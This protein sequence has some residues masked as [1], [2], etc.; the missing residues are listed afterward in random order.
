MIKIII[1]RMATIRKRRTVKKQ[2][3]NK[4]NRSQK[5]GWGRAAS[6]LFRRSGSKSGRAK[7]ESYLNKRANTSYSNHVSS[8]LASGQDPH[9]IL[10]E[11]QNSSKK[12]YRKDYELFRT[13]L[14]LSDLVSRTKRGRSKNYNKPTRMQ[15]LKTALGNVKFKSNA[16]R[17]QIDSLLEA[18]RIV[19][20]NIANKQQQ[21]KKS[22]YIEIKPE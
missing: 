14:A 6:R 17:S 11:L 8:K 1:S 9:T 20:D 16:F 22:G 15:N 18:Q 13:S 7:F 12:L 10:K 19:E 3:C 21:N 2:K 5:G 4:V